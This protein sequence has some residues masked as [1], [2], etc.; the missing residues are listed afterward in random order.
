MKL[1]N[2]VAIIG[3]GLIGGSLGLAIKKLRL[4]NEVIG[5]SRHKKTLLFAKRVR[6]ID[7]GVLDINI[8]KD[9]DLIIFATPVNTILELAGKISKLIKEG[10]L[11]TDVGSTKQ[12]IVSK[13]DK[14]FPNYLGAH[15]LAGSEK[16]SIMSASPDLFKG[17]LCILTPT[18][19]TK[20]KVRRRMVGLW[21][22]L[23]ARVIFSSADN[24]DKVISYVSHLPHAIAFSLIDTMP[25]SY[26]KFSSSGLRDTTRIAASDSQ[27]WADIFLS[28]E[29]NLI[30]SIEH[31]QARLSKIKFAIKSN[32]KRQLIKILAQAK[33]KREGLR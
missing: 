24:H 19:N 25:I 30:S 5:V 4:A 12:E 27:L 9:A 7:T 21:E 32:N 18:K 13:L 33:K 17:T 1:F 23:G 2:K 16:R 31:F 14:L 26:L 6:A 3:V 8:I 22:R 15:P 20:A 29:K 11:V 28:N 10:C